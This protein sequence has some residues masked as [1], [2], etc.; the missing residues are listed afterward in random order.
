MLRDEETLRRGGCENRVIISA[1]CKKRKQL[2]SSCHRGKFCCVL[3]SRFWRCFVT[4]YVFKPYIVRKNN[5][6]CFTEGTKHWKVVCFMGL[7]SPLSTMS[8]F[9]VGWIQMLKRSQKSAVEYCLNYFFAFYICGITVFGSGFIV[10]HCSARCVCV[11]LFL[12]LVY[13]VPY[14]WL[15]L[16]N[17]VHHSWALCHGSSKKAATTIDL[18]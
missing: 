3:L 17:G 7:F 13:I 4:N 11:L 6:R 14:M 5:S 1:L 10:A 8:L 12:A 15:F 2:I 18:P 9:T 16:S